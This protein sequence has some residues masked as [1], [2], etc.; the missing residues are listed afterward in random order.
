MK[1]ILDAKIAFCG[2]LPNV[3]PIFLNEESKKLKALL[4]SFSFG[5]FI[6]G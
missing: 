5:K 3:L 4:I 6:F 1:F 2:N